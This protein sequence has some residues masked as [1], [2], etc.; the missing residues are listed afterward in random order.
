MLINKK[1]GL[2]PSSPD[3]LRLGM[4]RGEDQGSCLNE[5]P[6]TVNRKGIIIKMHVIQCWLSINE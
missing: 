5:N 3:A 4:G 6:C 1:L 2:V